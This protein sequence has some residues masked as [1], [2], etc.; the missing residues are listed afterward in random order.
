VITIS[1]SFFFFFF[2]GLTDSCA[3]GP[4]T[5]G[6]IILEHELSTQ[7]V[8]A[9]IAAYPVMKAN[10]WNITSAAQLAGNLPYLNSAGSTSPVTPANGVLVGD[11][12]S[13]Q[14]PTATSSM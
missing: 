2:G 1:A 12:N 6:L 8:N 14:A 11:I 4:K 3:T 7:S 10:G 13:S 9:F 5:P